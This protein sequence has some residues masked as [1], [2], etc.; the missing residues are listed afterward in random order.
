MSKFFQSFGKKQFFILIAFSLF[1]IFSLFLSACSCGTVVE[2]PN[3]SSSLPIIPIKPTSIDSLTNKMFVWLDASIPSFLC[4]NSAGRLTNWVDRNNY[5]I[6]RINTT[7]TPPSLLLTSPISAT[8]KSDVGGNK[9]L[10]VFIVSNAA[11]GNNNYVEVKYEE[12]EYDS[13]NR[14]GFRIDTSSM[15]ESHTVEAFY[16]VTEFIKHN[17]G[18]YVPLGYDSLSLGKRFLTKQ[19]GSRTYLVEPAGYA[20]AGITLNEENSVREKNFTIPTTIHLLSATNLNI[21]KSELNG[22]LGTFPTSRADRGGQR[23]RELIVLT[24]DL[25]TLEHS[26]MVRYLVEKW[27]I[28]RHPVFTNLRSSYSAN[29]SHVIANVIDNDQLTTFVLNDSPQNAV[30]GKLLFEFKLIGSVLEPSALFSASQ[31]HSKGY[32]NLILKTGNRTANDTL[33]AAVKVELLRT[34]DVRVGRSNWH[35]LTN[36]AVDNNNGSKL[37]TF[38]LLDASNDFIGYR[39]VGTGNAIA[40]NSLEINDFYPSR[41]SSPSS[42]P[43]VTSFANT[44][45]GGKVYNTNIS[46]FTNAIT[47]NQNIYGLQESSFAVLNGSV[48]SLTQN[49]ASNYTLVINPFSF[50][51]NSVGHNPFVKINLPEGSTTNAGGHANH[52]YIKSI[53][54]A[55]RHPLGANKGYIGLTSSPF[56]VDLDKDG[57]LDLISGEYE[58]GFFFFS[59]NNDGTYTNYDNR[60]AANPFSGLLHIERYTTPA[61]GDLDGDGDMDMVSGGENGRFWFFSNN[62]DGTYTNY[63]PTNSENPFRGLTTSLGSDSYSAPFLVDLDGDRDLDLISGELRGEFWFFSNKGDGTYTNYYPTNSENPFRRFDVGQNSAPFLIDLDG[64]RDLDMISGDVNSRFWFFSNNNDGTYTEYDRDNP[65]N[66][67]YGLNAG[68]Y[69]LSK[70]CFGDVDGDGDLDMFCGRND[71]RFAYFMNVGGAFLQAE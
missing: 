37:F 49:S 43:W 57:D 27:N 48:H 44:L 12:E 20:K 33:K 26:N 54:F 24:N 17:N 39:L 69:G 16:L 40:N 41:I 59:N 7:T 5:T 65:A 18:K 63:R 47:F 68:G 35:I 62:G 58:Y 38:N 2:E 23:I 8:P 53:P 61:F 21:S 32:Y 1:I 10:D 22:T 42:S 19:D 28:P 50:Q 29:G 34:A 67:F 60:S 15:G 3:S 52:S 36:V 4:L 9:S 31:G 46:L 71:G 30:S 11:Q 64:D 14:A 6:V 66:P 51:S 45:P 25:T 55:V 70:P 56:L 13:E